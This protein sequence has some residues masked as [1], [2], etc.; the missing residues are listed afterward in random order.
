[1]TQKSY[2]TIIIDLLYSSYLEGQ[3][4]LSLP[5]LFSFKM[6]SFLLKLAV[7]FQFSKKKKVLECD[8]TWDCL[9]GI[10]YCF[11]TCPSRHWV[12]FLTSCNFLGPLGLFF[13]LSSYTW[14]FL[15][16]KTPLKPSTCPFPYGSCGAEPFLSVKLI[17]SGLSQVESQTM[18]GRSWESF[19][20]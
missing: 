15:E 19:L 20:S 13:T 2:Y 4:C 10:H 6:L 17:S 5:L 3:V 1:M 7:C 18:F 12:C 9:N 16:N 11:S 14:W 8:L